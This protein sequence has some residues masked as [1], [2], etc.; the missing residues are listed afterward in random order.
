MRSE[1]KQY[2]IIE[3]KYNLFKNKQWCLGKLMYNKANIDLKQKAD[4]LW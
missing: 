2:Y 3:F 4:Y 1:S